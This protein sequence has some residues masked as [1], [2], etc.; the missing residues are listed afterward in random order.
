MILL[1]THAA[2][3]VATE[4]KDLGR[5][6]RAIIE[7]ARSE[8]RL[9]VSAISFWEIAFLVIKRRLQI[10]SSSSVLRGTLLDTGVAEIPLTGDIAIL[11][12]ELT[13]L[14]GD[15]ADRFIAAT[16]ISHDAT[17]VTADKRLLSWRHAVRRQNAWR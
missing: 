9:A 4:S 3:W 1:D 5:Q 15:P 6:S 2:I 10:F 17:L 16:A 12:A 11:A 13:S 8:Q 14:H 7:Q